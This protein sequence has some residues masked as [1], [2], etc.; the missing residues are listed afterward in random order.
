KGLGV[1]PR[2][3]SAPLADVAEV[4]G[5][6]VADVGHRPYLPSR[7]EEAALL[8]ARTR[9]VPPRAGEAGIGGRGREPRIEE[10]GDTR[11]RVSDRSRDE[12]GVADPGA[13]AESHLV[14]LRL[15]KEE[16]IDEDP[17]SCTRNISPDDVDAVEPGFLA[18]AG[19]EPVDECGVEA[20]RQA[21]GDEGEAR[22]SRRRGDV[23]DV[24]GEGLPAEI[25]RAGSL[26]QEVD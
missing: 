7:P 16:Y 20:A 18:Q 5:E 22:R 21:E 2:P 13:R 1:Q 17:A 12:H 11:G 8:D 15:A 26:P 19:V 24:D 4:P 10:E 14:P 3:D 25:A 9:R 23:A 6:P